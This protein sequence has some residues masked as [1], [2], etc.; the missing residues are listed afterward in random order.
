M[1]I[2]LWTLL[3]WCVVVGIE[4]AWHLLDGSKAP[5]DRWFGENPVIGGAI[6]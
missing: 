1:I 5:A 4:I 2:L 6:F 3:A